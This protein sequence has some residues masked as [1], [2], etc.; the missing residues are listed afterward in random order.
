[1]ISRRCWWRFKNVPGVSSEHRSAEHFLARSLALEAGGFG[2]ED[3]GVDLI[4]WTML[5]TI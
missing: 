3:G 4:S 1:M 5:V 2:L